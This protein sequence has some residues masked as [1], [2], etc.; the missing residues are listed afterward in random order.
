MEKITNYQQEEEK[1]D[2]RYAVVTTTTVHILLAILF[3]FIKVWEPPDPPIPVAGMEVNFGMDAAGFGDIQSRAK[4]NTSTA[5]EASKPAPN[6]N[7]SQPTPSQPAD[8]KP[9]LP[10][11]VET[12]KVAESQPTPIKTFDNPAEDAVTVSKSKPEVKKEEPKPEPI[13]EQPKSEPNPA[14]QPEK[15]AP[16]VNPR[17]VI[18]NNTSLNSN[19]S[20]A[21]TGDHRPQG[22]NNGNVAGAVGDQGSPTGKIDARSLV[23]G[24][25]GG[26]GTSLNLDGW[27]WNASPD[28]RDPSGEAGYVTIRF[29]I[30]QAGEVL[31]ATISDRS[32]SQ[33]VA[34]FYRK[35]VLEMTFSPLT[36][37]EEDQATSTVGSI[38]FNLTRK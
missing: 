28:K 9:T 21:G 38:T 5:M 7:L 17:S 31:V 15:P 3:Y 14:K 37:S 13:K 34:E 26:S 6:S 18:S 19:S 25:G 23:G 32:V 11:P 30:N 22:N 1:K 4:A 2:K 24:S 10:T 8:V 16:T 29:K 27:R 35:Q 12:P 33:P 36:G 20:E